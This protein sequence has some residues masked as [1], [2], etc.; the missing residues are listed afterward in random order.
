LIV[1]IGRSKKVFEP[2]PNPK[3]ARKSPK[4]AKRSQIWLNYKQKD[5]VSLPKQKLI[6]Y[7]IRFQNVLNLTPTPKVAPK[8]QKIAPKDTKKTQKY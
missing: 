6:V 1:Y 3:I 7:I 2:Y 4:S 5:R 8:H